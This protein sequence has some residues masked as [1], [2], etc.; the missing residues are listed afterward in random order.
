VSERGTAPRVVVERLPHGA[1]L[2]LP[3]YATVGSAGADLRAA[4]EGDL[5]IAPGQRRLVPTGFRVAVPEGF[6]GQVRPRSGL[7]LR[8]G[9]SLPNSPGTIDA[10]YRGELQVLLVN[11]GDRPFRVRRG[12]R[13]AQ[14]VVAPVAAA[15]FVEAPSLDPTARGAGGFGSTGES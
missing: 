2:P 13:I 9:V 5:W 3:A 10:D 7:A 8:H 11:L 14:L 15:R 4:V 12:D 6:E 1:G